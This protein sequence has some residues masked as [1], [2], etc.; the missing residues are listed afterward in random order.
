VAEKKRVA[1]KGERTGKLKTAGLVYMV[2][3]TAKDLVGETMKCTTKKIKKKRKDASKKKGPEPRPG[4]SES[5]FSHTL[6]RGTGRDRRWGNRRQN[7]RGE[8][9]WRPG[10]SRGERSRGKVKR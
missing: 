8:S 9:S 5:D 7:L 3:R 1:S 6:T 10:N 4:T 2:R